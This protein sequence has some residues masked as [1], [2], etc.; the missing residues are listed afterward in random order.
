MSFLQVEN[1]APQNS[2]DP[3]KEEDKLDKTDVGCSD[4]AKVCADV[5]TH[6]FYELV[7]VKD[8]ASLSKEIDEEFG[9]SSEAK[10]CVDIHK[11][12]KK[13]LGIR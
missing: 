2:E 1:I 4:E 5:H 13:N 12:S 7:K 9:C 6:S 3:W 11:C 8:N 10:V